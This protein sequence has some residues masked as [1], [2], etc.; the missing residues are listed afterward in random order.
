MRL[1]APILSASRRRLRVLSLKRRKSIRRSL[2]HRVPAVE[3]SRE[4]SVRVGSYQRF[5]V[6]RDSPNDNRGIY[7]VALT[8]GRLTPYRKGE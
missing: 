7:I 3:Y 1:F 2:V 5:P 6:Y 4:R 8:G